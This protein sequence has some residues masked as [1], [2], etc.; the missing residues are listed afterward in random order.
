MTHPHDRAL[1]AA[2]ERA[3]ALL[4]VILTLLEHGV[5][6]DVIELL[7]MGDQRG[8]IR[9]G[10]LAAAVTAYIAEAGDGWRDIETAPR[11]GQA[12]LLLSAEYTD[13]IGGE[14]ITHAPKCAI[15][16][17]MPDGTSW[18]DEYGMLGG[19]TYTLA[20]TGLWLVK[21]GWFQPD[22]VTHWRPLPAPPAA[23]EPRP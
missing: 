21:D 5:P 15:G 4:P 2:E 18:V 23:Q 22:E 16:T 7:L 12:I 13:D 10:A 6:E 14:I 1:E 3:K 17:W 8:N 9:P 20:V 11:D 19:N